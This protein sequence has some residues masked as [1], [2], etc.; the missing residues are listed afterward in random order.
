[1]LRLLRTDAAVQCF[2]TVFFP[3]TGCPV[4]EPVFKVVEGAIV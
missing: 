2:S 3:K 1:M 4:S